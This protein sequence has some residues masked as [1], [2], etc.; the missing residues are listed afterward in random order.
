MGQTSHPKGKNA[1]LHHEQPFPTQAHTAASTVR[2]IASHATPQMPQRIPNQ[3]LSL[4]N[5]APKHRH[6]HQASK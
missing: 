6:L 3:P 1:H 2:H 4:A 5:L